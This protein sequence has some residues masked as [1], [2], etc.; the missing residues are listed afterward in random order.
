M[1]GGSA[2]CGSS[3]STV[4]TRSRTSWAAT[5]PADAT[6]LRAD[7]D[8]IIHGLMPKTIE[9]RRY[10]HQHPELSNREVET[11]KYLAK[12]LRELSFLNSGVRIELNDERENRSEVFEHRG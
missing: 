10:L 3:P 4:F 1:I 9:T 5:S 2:L 12:R 8:R 7:T 6:A 11:G